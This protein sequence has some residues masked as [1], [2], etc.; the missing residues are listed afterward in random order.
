MGVVRHLKRSII[1]PRLLTVAD[2]AVYTRFSESYLRSLIEQRKIPVIRVGRT[3]RLLLD[4]LDGFLFESRHE[5]R[6][7]APVMGGAEC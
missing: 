3:V 7:S 4:D 1:K 6:R 5:A 2:A